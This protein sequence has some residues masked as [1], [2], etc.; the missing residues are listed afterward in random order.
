MFLHTLIIYSL[1]TEL[2]RDDFNAEVSGKKKTRKRSGVKINM[3]DN[4][5]KPISEEEEKRE[6]RHAGIRAA[7]RNA[8]AR[9]NAGNSG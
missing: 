5:K 1:I 6:R 8:G 2:L 7:S 9:R 4:D 3:N